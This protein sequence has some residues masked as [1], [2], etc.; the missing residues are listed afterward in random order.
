MPV[1]GFERECR[2]L[3]RI[4]SRDDGASRLAQ[5]RQQRKV[6]RWVDRQTG[7]AKTLLELD[8]ERWR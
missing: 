8:A 3:A 4:L 6:R 5:Q 2:D 7:M 1:E